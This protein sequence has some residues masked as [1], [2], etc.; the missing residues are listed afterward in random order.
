MALTTVSR[1]SIVWESSAG[2]NE[3][4]QRSTYRSNVAYVKP[5]G[6]PASDPALSFAP[7]V[8]A[9]R[10]GLA[11]RFY[12]HLHQRI[13]YAPEALM[14]PQ[15]AFQYYVT[16]SAITLSTRAWTVVRSTRYHKAG[17][18]MRHVY[19]SRSGGVIQIY[20]IS[21]ILKGV[22]GL[23][24][25]VLIIFRI[26]LTLIKGIFVINNCN[27]SRWMIT[28]STRK[29]QHLQ[30]YEFCGAAHLE[31]QRTMLRPTTDHRS[32]QTR[33]IKPM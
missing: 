8:K 4:G 31:L 25:Q 33:I 7:L 26:E 24:C 28:S 13:L 11:Q 23:S 2:L 32:Y 9:R 6:L 27:I 10:P 3:S 19:K 22:L 15:A 1:L 29:G 21:R 17:S 14:R 30:S 16:R 12:L 18:L 5:A 20:T